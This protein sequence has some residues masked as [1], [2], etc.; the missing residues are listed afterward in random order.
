MEDLLL[1]HLLEAHLLHHLL[2][3]DQVADPLLHL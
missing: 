3:L 1:L 2:L